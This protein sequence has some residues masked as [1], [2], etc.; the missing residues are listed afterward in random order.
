MGSVFGRGKHWYMRYDV[1]TCGRDDTPN[2]ENRAVQ[3]GE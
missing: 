3:D 2:G 1:P